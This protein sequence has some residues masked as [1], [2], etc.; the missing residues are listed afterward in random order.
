MQKT[1]ANASRN[2]FIAVSMTLGK[3]EYRAILTNTIGMAQAVRGRPFSSAAGAPLQH[4]GDER[5][6]KDA[7]GLERVSVALVPGRVEAKFRP[8]TR[9][10]AL[11]GGAIRQQRE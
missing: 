5:K 1:R 6:D 4:A 7:G 11:S 3:F 9:S 10:H 8:G 2:F